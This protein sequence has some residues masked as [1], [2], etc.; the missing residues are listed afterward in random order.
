[1]SD[2]WQHRQF[3]RR[4]SFHQPSCEFDAFPIFFAHDPVQGTAETDQVIPGGRHLGKPECFQAGGQALCA[5]SQPACA[6]MFQERIWQTA[7]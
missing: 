5:L 6:L 2:A 4:S 3:C 1:M 7:L